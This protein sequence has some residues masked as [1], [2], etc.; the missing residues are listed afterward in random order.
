MKTVAELQSA[1]SDHGINVETQGRASKEPYIAALRDYHWLK[2]H[3]D[4]PLPPQISPMLLGNWADLDPEE[5]HRIEHDRPGWVV[6][7]K[8]DGV[9]ALLHVEG[10]RV[11][12]TSRYVSEVTYRL[13]EFQDNLPHLM[14]GL[15]SLDGTILDGELVFPGR[16][17][18][19]SRAI[20]RHPLQAAMAILSTS[21]E[22]ALR[23]QARPE[24]WLR[25]HAF[26]I[27]KSGGTDV[28]E[29][30]LQDRLDLLARAVAVADNPHLEA[31]PVFTI[32]RLAI[33]RRILEA[34]GE[35]TV[36]KQLDQPYEPGR[37]VGHWLKRKRE[38]TIEAF[39]TGFK[40]GN[41][42]R[43]NEDLV[44]ALEFST[45]HT[46]ESV[47]PIAW[48]SAWSDSER[49]MMTLPD[50]TNSPGL[51]PAYLGRRALIA[52][53]DEAA[54]SGRLRHARLRHW[55]D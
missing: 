44:G 29:Q 1:C 24:Q 9:R 25:F 55:L 40:R 13:G 52:G 32:G 26:D 48:V 22:Q 42:G 18:D 35:G 17:L 3:P 41:P 12:I 34:G 46:D 49:R 6:S 27:L 11:R 14:S 54:Q 28:T 8:L 50:Q 20:A 33:H 19:T 15:A 10:D 36:W 51:T 23:L 21:P 4:E 30:P 7:P 53:Q 16:S 45:R 2:D 39:V 47:R 38:T 5:A 43:G 37:R 31:V